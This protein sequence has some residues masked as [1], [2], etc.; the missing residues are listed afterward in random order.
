M[1][2]QQTTAIIESVAKVVDATKSEPNYWWALTLLIIPI[3]LKWY[4]SKKGR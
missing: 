3:I 4:L 1:Q 2:T